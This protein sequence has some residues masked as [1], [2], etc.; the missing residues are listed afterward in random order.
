M[1]PFLWLYVFQVVSIII[2][3][4]GFITYILHVT[5]YTHKHTQNRYVP[6]KK[7]ILSKEFKCIDV[8][9]L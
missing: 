7:G 3:V 8:L 4:F 2:L 5:E 6:I 1:L 9:F